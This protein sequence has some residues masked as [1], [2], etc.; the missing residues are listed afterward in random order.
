MLFSRVA[1][2]RRGT[3]EHR[4][5][6]QFTHAPTHRC[7]CTW[8]GR[9]TSERNSKEPINHWMDFGSVFA[10]AKLLGSPLLTCWLI[11][12]RK[13]ISWL[14]LKCQRA[15]L[16]ARATVTVCFQRS[17]NKHLGNLLYSWSLRASCCF[18]STK[19]LHAISVGSSLFI[20]TVSFLQ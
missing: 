10:Q 4:K 11:T 14:E 5:F 15:V 13:G 7:V 18:H 17:Y 19:P 16:S 8:V 3:A 12:W 6:T 2:M 9:H 20:C 1:E